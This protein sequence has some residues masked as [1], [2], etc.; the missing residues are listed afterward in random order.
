MNQTNF[1]V[2]VIPAMTGFFSFGKRAKVRE[3]QEVLPKHLPAVIKAEDNSLTGVAKY[4]LA[5]PLVTSVTKYMKKQEKH[6]ITGVAKYVL[7][8]AIAE[9]N[10]PLPTGV[11]KYLAQAAK[12][13]G[14]PRKSGVAKYLARQA[15]AAPNL[16]LLTGV[17]KYQAE[18]DLIAKKKAIAVKIQQYK[19]ADL[20]AAKAAREAAEAAY[21]SSRLSEGLQYEQ[22]VETTATTRLGRYIQEQ[23]ELLK[24]RPKA[25][26]VS[27]YINKKIVLDSQKPVVKL[28][29]VAKYLKDQE[30]AQSKKPTLTG[31]SRYLAKQPII[32]NTTKPKENPVQSGVAR[33]LAGQ[34][35]I[36]SNK[37]ALSGVAKYLAKQ[38]AQLDQ[39]SKDTLRLVD[40]STVKPLEGEFIPANSFAPATG[41]SRYLERQESVVSIAKESA[42]GVSRYL[43]RQ[44]R[45]VRQAMA[46]AP[47]GVDRYLLKRA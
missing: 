26:S 25:T 46:S 35:A 30:L 32:K 5:A 38:Q 20:A 37:P 18:Q 8:Q 41:V 47:T 14:A 12:Q 16:D 21:E 36:E 15:L 22:A 13:P 2:A 6:P 19:E 7:R 40:H 31:V 27:K 3:I 23:A 39:I 34:S 24:K 28:S 44:G 11:A 1:G 4:L 10:A 43:E 33:Y 45:P 17:A 42:T 9:R 29:K